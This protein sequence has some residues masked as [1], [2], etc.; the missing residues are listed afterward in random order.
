[1]TDRGIIMSAPM[2][3]ATIREIEHSGDGKTMTRRLAWQEPRIAVKIGDGPVEP[4]MVPTIWQ[5]VKPGDRLW[6]R[7]SAWAVCLSGAREPLWCYRAD[8][9]VAAGPDRQPYIWTHAK[10]NY[11]PAIHMRAG[12]PA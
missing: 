1:M 12:C 6:V 2:V 3:L 10:R 11:C 5:K 9:V 4:I 7:E 8:N